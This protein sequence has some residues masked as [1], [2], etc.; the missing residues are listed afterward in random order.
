M[1]LTAPQNTLT[2]EIYTMMQGP[3]NLA[4]AAVW[5][6]WDIKNW[7]KEITVPT[8]MIGAK[9]DTPWIQKAMEEQKA[10]WLKRPV[11]FSALN[12]SHL[13][14][15]GRPESVYAWGDWI[16]FRHRCRQLLNASHRKDF[17]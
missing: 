8:L 11:S 17:S 5:L 10:K 14:M 2:G 16:Y 7:L 6:T 12:G 1:D 15:W 4:S 9:H 3:V 13:A